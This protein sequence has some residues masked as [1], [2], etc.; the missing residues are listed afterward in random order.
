MK[1]YSENRTLIINALVGIKAFQPEAA[2]EWI[3]NA[4]RDVELASLGID[5]MAVIDLCMDIEKYTGREVLIDELV[6]N[7]T[8]NKLAKHLSERG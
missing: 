3:A 4:D 2:A 8:L 5:S 1:T 6:D 7:P